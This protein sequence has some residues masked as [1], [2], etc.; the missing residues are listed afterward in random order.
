[1]HLKVVCTLACTGQGST[2]SAAQL[3]RLLAESDLCGTGGNGQGPSGQGI[4]YS[5]LSGHSN[6]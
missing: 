3:E 2:L 4:E 6:V 5:L 1:M